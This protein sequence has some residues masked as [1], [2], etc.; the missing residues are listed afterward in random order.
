MLIQPDGSITEIKLLSSELNN[1]AL[2][3]KILSRVKLIRFPAANVIKT[4]VN[5]SFDFLPY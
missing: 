1:P 2:E 4:R 5:Y 3:R